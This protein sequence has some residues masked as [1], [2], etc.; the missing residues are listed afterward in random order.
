MQV[1]RIKLLLITLASLISVVANAATV[2]TC[3]AQSGIQ[4]ATLLE[5]YTSEGCDS[6]PPADRWLS[7]QKSSPVAGLVVPLAFHVDYW[8]NLGWKDPFGSP[9]NTRRQHAQA[10]FSGAKFVY[11]PQFLRDG[12]DWRRSGNV[13]G[14]RR[15]AAASIDMELNHPKQGPW[16]VSAKVRTLMPNPAAEV[17]LAVYENNLESRVN[18]GENRG[19]TLR[20]DFVVR[21]KYGPLPLAADGSLSVNQSIKV[22]DAWK[23]DDLGVAIV[24]Q[25]AKTGDVLQAV[26]R[27]AC[28]N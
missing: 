27:L 1:G 25:D 15:D 20:H 10:G 4:R 26:S 11:T 17:W 28:R 5:L 22:A 7:N 21:Q 18:A 24:V 8:D 16:S 19:E 12:K 2:S 23:R 3:T 14:D 6:C 9:E 13:L